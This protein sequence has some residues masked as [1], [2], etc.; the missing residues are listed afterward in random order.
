ME[1]KWVIQIPN[2]VKYSLQELLIINAKLREE[3]DESQ[4]TIDG[5]EVEAEQVS[6]P[7]KSNKTVNPINQML[8]H[9]YLW[10]LYSL[11]CQGW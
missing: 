6:T 11:W 7:A 9:Q 5:I 10:K 3:L 2:S 1:K 8:D 4:Q